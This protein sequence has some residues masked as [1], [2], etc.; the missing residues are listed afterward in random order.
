[1][2]TKDLENCVAVLLLYYSFTRK[3][4]D[5]VKITFQI[6]SFRRGMRNTFFIFL[7]LLQ[8]KHGFPLTKCAIKDLYLDHIQIRM[9]KTL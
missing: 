2:Q 7:T 5:L 1:M 4:S 8:N 9:F 3:Y 6:G